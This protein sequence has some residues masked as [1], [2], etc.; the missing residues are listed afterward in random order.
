MLTNMTDAPIATRPPAAYRPGPRDTLMHALAR[1]VEA[2]GD[3]EFAN[4]GG[5]RIT[6]GEVDARAN[7]LARAFADL[8]VAKGDRVVSIF[9]TSMDVL[10]CWFAINKLGA[11]W[12]PINTAYRGEF[13]RHQLGDSGARIAICD[14]HYLERL[15]EIA[16]LLPDLTLILCRGDGPFADCTI[17]IQAL[18]A[19]RGGDRSPLPIVVEP[20]DLAC[21]IYTSG[22]TGPSKG[23]MIS[24]NYMCMQGRQQL[25][26]V[27]T[28]RE[29]ISWTPLPLFHAAAITI[30]LGALVSGH[31]IA[32][33][34][35]FSVSGFW[36]DIEASGA[37]NA[38]LMAAI[39]SL[40]AHAP[41]SDA[42]HRCRG[43]L[44]MIYGQ[45]ISP[46]VRVIWKKRFGVPI[47][48]S[49]AYGQTEGVRL[50]M[51]LPDETPPETCAGRV[52]D[53]FEMMIVDGDDQ[54]LPDG[55]VGEIVY[56]PREANIM[57]EGYWQRPADTQKAWRNL[58]MHSGDLGRIEGGYLFFADRAKDYLRSRGENV[59][60]FEVER[61]YS[62]H[63]AIAE[64]A[65]HATGAQD[66]E[67]E[68]KV[69]I[70]LNKEVSITEH[71]LCLWS[72]D[73]L[74]H[75]AVP[76]FYEFR[77]ELIKNPTGRVLKYR[78]R[79]EGVT[80]ATWDREV[81]GVIVRRR[82]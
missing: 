2:H 24:H 79:D 16:D 74:P 9:D 71:E 69:T 75:F 73:N 3:D 67:D 7:A 66:A 13:L 38:Q 10:I 1:C 72:I 8:G 45:P 64:V 35:R 27:P 4:I 26:A 46:D 39:F 22:T 42:M 53:E 43:Q 32:V 12:V 30:V 81:A 59:S 28:T 55:Q 65:V 44:Q 40:V 76:R 41:D 17:P 21:L 23:C 6:Y 19:Y 18:D 61:V 78:L 57:F 56:R 82:R 29:D 80:P 70:V 31:R 37:T 34:P 14:P 15:T 62:G 49:W 58:W 36:D 50:T 48:S 11:I 63:P 77:H 20:A 60:S 54:P 47:V 51:V 33:C 68:I 52:S 25:R 5:D